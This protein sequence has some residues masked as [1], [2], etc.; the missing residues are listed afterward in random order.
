MAPIYSSFFATVGIDALK[1]RNSKNL[2]EE[3]E[4]LDALTGQYF[5]CDAFYSLSIFVA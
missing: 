5:Y 2:L 4:F 1:A 3:D